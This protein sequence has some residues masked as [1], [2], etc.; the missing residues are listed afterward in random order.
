MYIYYVIRILLYMSLGRNPRRR[1]DGD[2]DGG[3]LS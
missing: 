2:Q 1:D 3:H